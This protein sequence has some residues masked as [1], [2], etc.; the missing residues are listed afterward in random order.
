MA[1]RRRGAGAMW[2]AAGLLLFA[3]GYAVANR[4]QLTHDVAYRLA[5]GDPQNAA[6]A[7][8]TLAAQGAGLLAALVWLPRRWMLVLLGL[9]GASILVNIGYSGLVGELLGAGSLAWLIAEARQ[10]GNAA[11]EFAGPLLFA[12]AQSVAAVA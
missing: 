3:L 12:L 1:G 11:G 7:F 8:A 6:R 5:A 9:A 2:I 4:F 10:A